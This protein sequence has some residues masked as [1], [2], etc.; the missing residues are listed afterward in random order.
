MVKRLRWRRRVDDEPQD[1]VTKKMYISYNYYR[2]SFFFCFHLLIFFPIMSNSIELKSIINSKKY[3]RAE[4]LITKLNKYKVK[5]SKKKRLKRLRILRLDLRKR[6]WSCKLAI[7]KCFMM[8][9]IV[10]EK[11]VVIMLISDWERPRHD[12]G[13]KVKTLMRMRKSI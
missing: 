6:W 7:A 3:T 5:I 2:I 10:Q 9:W 4:D 12:V 11:T 13:W 1:K 8:F